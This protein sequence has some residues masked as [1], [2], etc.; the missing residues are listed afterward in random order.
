LSE[1]PVAVF[2]LGPKTAE[3]DD[4]AEARAQLDKALSKVPEVQPRSVAIFGGMIDPAKLRF[5]LNRMPASDARDWNE[6]EGWAEAIAAIAL[7]P[8]K[9]ANLPG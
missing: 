4:L 7:E 1:L 2:A 8:Q 5:P 6:I 3:P 9:L